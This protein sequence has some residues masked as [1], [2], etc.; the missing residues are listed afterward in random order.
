M[1]IKAHL[2][3]TPFSAK[4]G[5][6][7]Y[8]ISARVTSM[9]Q[10]KLLHPAILLAFVIWKV[11]AATQVFSIDAGQVEPETTNL[12]YYLDPKDDSLAPLERATAQMSASSNTVTGEVKGQLLVQGQKS[13]IRLTLSQKA[14][15]EVRLADPS[16]HLGVSFERFEAND[17]RRILKFVK[18]PKPSNFPDRPGLLAVDTSHFGKSSIKIS[19]PYDLPQG[20]YGITI[21]GRGIGVKVYCFGVD[22]P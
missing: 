19:I 7:S 3:Y 2:K 22:T 9:R 10:L 21:S 8:L 17:G 16:Q 14:E 5:Y 20:E 6:R 1:N 18:D 4:R 11:G 15:F 12:V 13:P